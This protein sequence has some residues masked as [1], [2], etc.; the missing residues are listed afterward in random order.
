MNLVVKLPA[1][2]V[3]LV[4]VAIIV[5]SVAAYFMARNAM[6]RE[7]EGR[8]TAVSQAPAARM[9]DLLAT[10]DADLNALTQDKT[11]IEAMRAFSGAFARMDAPDAELQRSY[12]EDNPNP[13][14]EK[15]LLDSAATGSSYDVKHGTYHPGFR[16]RLVAM[17]Y[18]DIFLI[19]PDGNIV[20]T[21][22]KELDYATNLVTGPWKDS[23]LGRAFRD[24]RR[25]APGAEPIFYDFAPYAPS[26]GAAAAFIAAPVFDDL[27]TSLGVLAI[28]MPVSRI[29]A[30]MNAAVSAKGSVATYLVGR[31]GLLRS[32]RVDTPENDILA[33]QADNPAVAAAL[34]GQKGLEVYRDAS[35]RTV[36]AAFTPLTFHGTT[37]GV[38]TEQPRSDLVG[39]IN[40][41]GLAFVV[42]GIVAL[43]A[44]TLI[45]LG[46]SRSIAAPIRLVTNA[47]SS[48]AQRDYQAEIPRLDRGDEIG[49]MADGLIVMRDALEA[50][51]IEAREAEE[52]RLASAERDR[53]R[54]LEE[55][56]RKRVLAAEEHAQQMQFQKEREAD[57]KRQ[58]AER[59][60]QAEELAE[61]VKNLAR[62]LKDMSDG[63]LNVSIDQFFAEE[64]KPLRLDFNDAV[65]GLKEIVSA[66]S[67]STE[68]INA[69]VAEISNASRDL[70]RRTESSAASIA[71][72][73]ETMRQMRGQVDESTREIGT[74]RDEAVEAA[75]QYPFVDESRRTC[76]SGDAGNG[77]LV[78]RD[79]EDHRGHR[80][81]RVPDQPARSQ[82]RSRSRAGGRGRA[83]LRRRRLGSAGAGPAGDGFRWGNQPLDLDHPGTG[84]DR[85]RPC[86]AE[87][88]RNR[89]NRGPGRHHRPEDR[90]C[91]GTRPGSEERDRR[92]QYRD[93]STRRR[94]ATE[95]RD[96]RGND[97]GDAGARAV[98]WRALASRRT[99]PGL[100]RRRQERS[101]R[102]GVTK[103]KRPARGPGVWSSRRERND[104]AAFA[105]FGPK[106]P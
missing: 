10:I 48:I 82:C 5:T 20:Y 46:L 101:A 87:R 40:R 105:A 106:R 45:A 100:G 44:A 28:Q 9:S 62:S 37:W 39:P 51:E 1:F 80:R 65:R 24:A 79:R 90:R 7:V 16:A 19:D 13:T 98:G 57:A 86:P 103:E 18:Y 69:H 11:V 96:V 22:F 89:A 52:A 41:M 72:T 31:D 104:Q 29:N 6:M 43:G 92:G 61:V 102:R 34:A 67:L 25:L 54:D 58:Q 88:H 26:H 42:I 70:A 27:G 77:K 17:D 12:I 2:M 32:D 74:V 59:E 35:G 63:D 49:R 8:L 55:A 60:R 23:D 68:T 21:V 53:Q 84:Q 36:E 91:R 4:A 99:L 76:R 15:H 14:G 66:I 33:T 73:S 97:R 83:G 85:R 38:V 56:E 64:Y 93:G 3:G 81:H 95:C 50:A 94:D 75:E 47:L 78:G 30:A 71:E